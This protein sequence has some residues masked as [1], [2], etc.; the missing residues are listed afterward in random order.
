MDFLSRIYEAFKKLVPVIELIQPDEAGVRVTLGT[1]EKVLGPGW[2]FLW[3]LIHE[4]LYTTVTT[5]VKDLRGQSVL[6]KDHYDM[7]IGGAIR[8]KITDIRKAMLEVQDFDASLE[9]LSLG[10]LLS[11][12]S[13]TVREG[14]QN[15]EY[16]GDA[17]LK[18]I[19]EEA[20]GWGLKIQKVYVTDLG[21]TRNIRL[22]TTGPGVSPE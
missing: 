18:K 8:Y 21:K 20:S 17:V 11:V 13:T 9:A 10:A 7:V 14:L 2:Y 6:S 16:F 4:I 1:R 19:R 12:A 3:P 22:L 15:T 5:Q